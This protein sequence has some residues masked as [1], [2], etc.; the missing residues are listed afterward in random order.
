M[1]CAQDV[2]AMS[3]KTSRTNGC[4][5]NF[6]DDGRGDRSVSRDLFMCV[7]WQ[8]LKLFKVQ[9]VYSSRKRFVWYCASSGTRRLPEVKRFEH[10]STSTQN[11]QRTGR[12]IF[13]FSRCKTTAGT[14]TKSPVVD[15]PSLCQSYSE[16]AKPSKSR[17]GVSRRRCV[18]PV[19][20]AQW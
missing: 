14:N 7:P 17:C 12:M 3:S 13:S 16:G 11:I 19:L 2:V 10:P 4:N 1:S 20:S 15:D 6:C 8:N 9:N 18:T 5:E